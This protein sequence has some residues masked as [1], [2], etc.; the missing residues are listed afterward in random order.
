MEHVTEML[1]KIATNARQISSSMSKTQQHN[2]LLIGAG[3][4]TSLFAVRAVKRS[5]SGSRSIHAADDLDRS[6]SD[7]KIKKSMLYTRTGDKGTSSLYTGERR[8]K[9]DPVFEALGHQDEL[10]AAIGIAREH[11]HLNDNGLGNIL[12][13]IQSRLFD[14]GA[15]VATPQNTGSPDKLAYTAFDSDQT[16]VLEEWIDR[17]DSQLVPLTTFIIPSGGLSSTHLHMARVICRRAERAVVPLVDANEV[18][19]EVG[20]YL[21]RLSDF[22]FIA[23]RTAAFRE[24][25]EEI[26]WR[27]AK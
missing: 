18:D 24:N 12:V 1:S 3:T 6:G 13:E 19:A 11:C 16:V 9:T 8:S 25:R 5:F 14:L 7:E 21:N 22:L 20:R 10:C 2:A 15:A 17:L 4:I 27:K 23:A 26:E